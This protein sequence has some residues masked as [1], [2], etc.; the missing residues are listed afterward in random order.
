MG[1]L[2]RLCLDTLG[3]EKPIS[4]FQGVLEPLTSAMW[5]VRLCTLISEERGC[6]N[7]TLPLGLKRL[8]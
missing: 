3:E 2:V 5:S 8:K 4:R 7:V 1:L 6:D